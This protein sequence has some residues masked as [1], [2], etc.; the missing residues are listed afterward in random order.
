MR[1]LEICEMNFKYESD[2]VQQSYQIF[3]IFKPQKF[4]MLFRAALS[5]FDLELRSQW[6]LGAVC[7]VAEE[8]MLMPTAF[9]PLSIVSVLKKGGITL[10]IIHK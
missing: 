10:L 4:V 7:S 3:R 2:L 5:R 6:S 8:R 9:V 1:L